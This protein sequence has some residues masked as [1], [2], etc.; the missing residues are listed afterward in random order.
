MDR[1]QPNTIAG[2]FAFATHL[3]VGALCFLVAPQTLADELKP[4][5]APILAKAR[6]E[7]N[8]GD[9]LRSE[10]RQAMLSTKRSGG[11]AMKLLDQQDAAYRTAEQSFRLALKQDK[12]NPH[13]LFE[14]GRF[15]ASRKRFSEA[16]LRFE[17]AL[18]S[19]RA[20]RAFGPAERAD[21]LRSF[22][23]A[24]DRSGQVRRAVNLYRHA[25]EL[26]PDDQRNRISYAVGLCVAGEPEDAIPLLRSWASPA[27]MVEKAQSGRRALGLYT[28]AY[29]QEQCGFIEDARDNYRH[30]YG[31]A[32][33]SGPENIKVEAR[34]A[35][36]RVAA[37]LKSLAADKGA[38]EKFADAHRLCSEGVR[39][40]Q[41]ALLDRA[42]FVK[43]R[44]K[45]LRAK[46]DKEHD[47]AQKEGPVLRMKQAMERLQEA[48]K[49][50]P[51]CGRAHF[52]LA[53]CH[54]LMNEFGSARSHFEAASVYD[55][56]G[57]AVLS[58]SGAVHLLCGEWEQAKRTYTELLTVEPE[59]SP[60]YMGLAN[61]MVRQAESARDLHAALDYL[62]RA[63]QLGADARKV[64]S[65]RGEA[66]SMLKL[67][68]R[69][70][71]LPRLPGPTK[72]TRREVKKPP[73]WKG[74]NSILD[75]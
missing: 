64:A 55:P 54:L 23:G 37:L 45:W 71:K 59:C 6:K 50:Y 24:L 1:R 16:A 43:A 52:E 9:E 65:L 69:G 32:R 60:A 11:E 57:P 38:R 62:E 66:R 39:L 26:F 51:G 10:A 19:P 73:P 25:F 70:G 5:V 44:E 74:Q 18:L 30:A 49:A 40:K 46:S 2:L 12:D 72:P 56:L 14:F 21:A 22:A 35:Y 8:K 68:Q 36:R 41:T 27:S 15:L 75:D 31:A 7:W 33:E 58:E 61:T 42:A 63:E 20:R 4:D 3:C 28:L 67:I 17:S 47:S 34:G 29:A 48:L 13:A 53:R